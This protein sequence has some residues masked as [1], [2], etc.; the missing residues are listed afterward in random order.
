MRG[1][2]ALGHRRHHRRRARL[3]PRL[4][5]RIAIEGGGRLPAVLADAELDPAAGGPSAKRW[6]CSG[7]TAWSRCAAPASP[8]PTACRAR[9]RAELDFFRNNVIHHFVA[10]AIIA[11]A[12]G[13][14]RPRIPLPRARSRPTRAGSRACSSSSSC[15]GSARASRPSSRRR[16]RR[17]P[18]WRSTA[19]PAPA[20]AAPNR[21]CPRWSTLRRRL[22]H[23][24]AHLDHL[25]GRR[26]ARVRAQRPAEGG[27]GG[28]RRPDRARGGVEDD[29]GERDGVADRR[30][31]F[32]SP[33]T[34]TT[35]PRAGAACVSALPGANHARRA[36]VR[37]RPLPPGD[38][39]ERQV[40]GLTRWWSKPARDRCRSS[41]R[42]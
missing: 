37:H 22:S 13:A 27:R 25:A 6:R 35:R 9:R 40:T 2:V 3:A 42:P 12:R 34:A 23:R 29:A 16:G 1:G 21:S 39:L 41:S 10:I 33:Q 5:R 28:C 32:E 24:R 31:A 30:G 38:A 7:A 26:P 18:S 19:R 14:R 8:R 20:P 11:A 17:W 15:I 36:G 4:L